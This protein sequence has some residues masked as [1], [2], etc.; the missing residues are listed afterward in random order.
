MLAEGNGDLQT[1]ICV[2]VGSCGETQTMCHI[3]ESCPLTKLS[4]G[5]SRLGTLRQDKS[6]CPEALSDLK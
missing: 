3:V 6:S 2:L 5:L 1:L 4:G